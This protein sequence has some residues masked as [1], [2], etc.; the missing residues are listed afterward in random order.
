LFALFRVQGRTD[1]ITGFLDPVKT[2]L[3][4]EE[5]SQYLKQKIGQKKKPE[6]S[7]PPKEKS[8]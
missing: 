8:P 2:E 7:L 1:L 6:K 3:L 5:M 4:R